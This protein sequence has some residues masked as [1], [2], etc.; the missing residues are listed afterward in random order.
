MTNNNPEATE[1]RSGRPPGTSPYFSHQ[2]WASRLVAQYPEASITEFLTVIA[3]WSK[4]PRQQAVSCV[5]YLDNYLAEKYGPPQANPLV[6]TTKELADLSTVI[7]HLRG[8]LCDV[9]IATSD[10]AHR[11]ILEAAHARWTLVCS[12]ITSAIGM[13][14]VCQTV[15]T[16]CLLSPR[17]LELI[18]EL[19]TASA[20][21]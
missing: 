16:A 11:E 12:K 4:L 17:N 19:R 3:D 10:A 21:G 8:V 9:A 20:D 1:T 14:Y 18:A 6:L 2:D 15:D 13:H 5:A 7:N